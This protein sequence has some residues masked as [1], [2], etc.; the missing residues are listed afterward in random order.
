MRMAYS[1][2][3]VIL[4]GAVV[5]VEADEALWIEGEDYVNSSFNGHGWYQDSGIS[6][7]LLSPGIPSVSD[8]QW[9]AHFTSNNH[10]DSATATYRFDI[11]E[12]GSYAWWIRLN[13]FR[14]SHGGADYAYRWRPIDGLWRPWKDLDVSEARRND[15]DLVDPGIDIR[16]IAWAFGAGLQLS[17]GAYELQ[18]R[19][20]DNAGA[21]KENHGGIDV[22]ALTNFPWA[23]TGIVPPDPCTTPAGPGDWFTLMAGPDPFSEESIIDVSHLIEKPAGTHGFLTAPGKDFVFEDGRVAKFWAINAGMVETPEAQQR[24]AR[25][26]A[27]HGINMI[28][29]HPVEGFLGPMQSNRS[30]RYLDP[31]RLDKLDRWFAALKAQGIYMTWSVFYHQVVTPEDGIDP[32]LYNELPDRGAGKDTYGM[33]TFISEYQDAQWQY[34]SMLLEHVNPY[35]QRA[36]KDD[37]ALAIVENRNEDS[38]F[39]HNPLSD[40][41]VRGQSHPLHCARLKQ[42]WQQWVK[43]RYMTD[44][45]LAAAWGA[46]CK[47]KTIYN[48]DGSIRSRPDSVDEPDMYI[49]AAW[50]MEADGPRWNKSAERARMGDFIRFLA[51]MQRDS[52]KL[53]ESRMRN[54]GYG[55]VLV[56]TAWRA[57]GPAA[58]AA[59]L[60]TDDALDAIDRHNYFGGGAGGHGIEAGSV[61]NDTHMTR[62]GR[63]ILSSGLWQVEDKPFL[64]TE[65][66]QK[67]PNQ[68]KAEIAPLVA[69]YGMGL[70]GWDACYHF[71]GSRSY[72]GNGWPSMRSYVT[73]TPHYIGQFPAVAVALYNGHFREGALVAARRFA[74]HEAFSG[75]DLLDQ[76]YGLVGYDENELL[77]HGAVPIEALAAGRVTLKIE[78]DPRRPRTIDLSPYWDRSTGTVV[79]NTGQFVWDASDAVVRL[80]SDRTQGLIGFPDPEVTYDLPAVTIDDIRTEFVSLLLTSLDERPIET[81]QHILVTAMAQDKQYGTVYSDD[82]TQLI[83]TGGPPLLLEPVRATLVLKGAPITSVRVVDVYGVPTDTGVDRN[84]NRFAI[85]GRYATYYYQIRRDIDPDTADLDGRRGVDFADFAILTSDWNAA[86][87]PLRG[88]LN[89]D[90]IVDL[91]DLAQWVRHWL[92][93]C[94]DSTTTE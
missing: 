80:Q 34:L 65:W 87:T 60:W 56:S 26:Y 93:D 31:D 54:T 7:D 52:Y 17:P 24:Q 48:G 2:M 18:I 62:P 28:R 21:D 77:A 6:K 74:E 35:T 69:F 33:T 19:L 40:G 36:Y 16:F 91:W 58:S 94:E 90:S 5:P 1:I 25:F 75:T 51:E 11:E 12:G 27:K 47:T 41:F 23:P 15:I 13:P 46:G 42:M 79:S 39:F 67:P 45:A 64:I 14:N 57:G 3:L 63:G 61:N 32:A 37:A 9:H 72:M 8:G 89:H 84:G 70:Q 71:A 73:E 68:W 76:C 49:Y 44:A 38:V 55:G 88:D 86:G 92:A 78:Q 82:G 43:G 30:V 29:L 4:L 50:E 59:N 10:P 85:D 83:E 20:S 66:T 22:M 53:F 81:S